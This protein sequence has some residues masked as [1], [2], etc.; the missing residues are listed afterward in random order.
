MIDILGALNNPIPKVFSPINDITLTMHTDASNQGLGAQ[1]VRD[2]V[3][4]ATCALHGKIINMY[5][6]S[7]AERPWP[8]PL[9]CITSNI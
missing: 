5:C 6:I 3:E 1:L 7:P 4:G 9:L 2:N 8:P